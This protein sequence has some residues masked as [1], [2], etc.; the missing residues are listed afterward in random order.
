MVPFEGT[1]FG[2]TAHGLSLCDVMPTFEQWVDI[3]QA[4]EAYGLVFIPHQQGLKPAL[5]I[6][7]YRGLLSDR[8]ESR[9]KATATAGEEGTAREISHVRSR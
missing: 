6:E 2:C 1:P 7:L 9:T 3:V 5:G 4:F 8:S